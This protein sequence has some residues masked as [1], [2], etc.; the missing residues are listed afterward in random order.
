MSAINVT[1]RID[2]SPIGDLQIITF[3]L[4]LLCLIM[5]G[6]DVQALGYVAPAIIREWNIAN[7][8]LGPV[9]GAG[10]FGVLIGALGFS[11]L[12]DR[13][14]RRPVL[15]AATLFFSAL[16]ILTARARSVEDLLLLRFISGI[17]LGGIIPNATALVGEYSP[18]RSRV[19]LMMGI[20]VGFTAGAAIGGFVAAWLIPA[21]GWRSV[22]YF[23]G[24]IPL[25]IA[26][27][28]IARLPESLQF[29]VLRGNGRDRIASYLKRID[30]T[31][32]PTAS[33]E[34]VLEEKNLRGAPVLHLF[35]EGRAPVTILFWVVNFM[36][37][38]NLYSLS[39]WLPTVV[40]DAGYST[41]TAVLVG[42][43]LQV[44][45]T[46]GTFGLAWL[47]ARRGFIPMLAAS[48][49]VA[50]ASI[51]LIGTPGLSLPLLFLIVFVAGWCVVGSQPGI[52][53]FEA[54]YYPTYLRSTG[55]GWGLGI[56][57]A[58]AIVGPVLGG[59]LMRLNWPI[60]D[61]FLAAAIPALVSAIAILSMRWVVKTREA[62][63]PAKL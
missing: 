25:V 16:T 4:C 61:I 14:G 37:L 21:F 2:R 19:T 26:L 35:R 30:P 48:F 27:A 1:E 31:A 43:V 49:A 29:M 33:T 54:T 12:A 15:I 45:G 18:R 50:F 8:A 39:S 36:N 53:A 46:I 47:I 32:S 55:I 51:A 28:M 11:V 10:N 13:I 60:R 62:G 59:E 44:G 56:G 57:R 20:T 24:T 3:T 34:Y 52:N 6:F 41:S 5:D 9:F 7:S 17:G 23:G 22:F 40:R 42:T 38:L 58:G 63:Q